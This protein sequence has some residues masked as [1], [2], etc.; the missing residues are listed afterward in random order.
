MK[1]LDK[2]HTPFQNKHDI[3]EYVVPL[4][5]FM[6]EVKLANTDKNQICQLRKYLLE[7]LKENKRQIKGMDDIMD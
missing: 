1:Y 2:S 4:Q 5:S 3:I 6:Q 7:Q